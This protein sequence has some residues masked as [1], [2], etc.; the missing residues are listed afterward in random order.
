GGYREGTES[1]IEC[2]VREV[3]EETSCHLSAGRFQH[4]FSL[5]CPDPERSEGRVKGEFFIAY[6]IP[7][8]ELTITEGKLL[9]VGPDDISKLQ[10]EL[11]PV[12]IMAL[13]AFSERKV[14][15]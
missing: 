14:T 5:D 9:V 3:A 15:E 13:D 2:V 12:T 4:L 8:D 11:T 1:F 7:I 6:D 10:N